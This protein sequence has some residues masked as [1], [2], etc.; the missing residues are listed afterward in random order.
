MPILAIE[1]LSPSQGAQDIL[2]KFPLY[3]EAGIRSCWLVVP[4][5]QSVVVYHDMEQAQTFHAGQI[6]D[7]AV[8][9]SLSVEAIFE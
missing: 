5:T 1:V 2:D 9:L 7:S 4:I 6:A 3:F 8:N